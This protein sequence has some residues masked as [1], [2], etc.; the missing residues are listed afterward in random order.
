[1][2]LDVYAQGLGSTSNPAQI[3]DIIG[4]IRSFISLLAPAAAIAFFVMFLFGGFKFIT[5]GGDAKAAG[6]ARST[7][8]YAIIGVVLV[9]A[10]WL[11]LVLI[12]QFTGVDV[13]RVELPQ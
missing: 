10:S 12:K 7:M 11:I 1:M 5:S 3:S 8:T 6:S 9:V 13:T 4:I 2:G